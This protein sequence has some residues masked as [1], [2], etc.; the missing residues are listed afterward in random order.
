MRA[1]ELVHPEDRPRVEAQ[2]A[3][4]VQ[5]VTVTEPIQFRVEHADGTYRYAEAVVSNLRDNPSVAG[6]RRQPARHHRAQGG[7][8]PAPPRGAARP[9]HRAS[10]TAP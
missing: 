9:A 7:R 6:L 1:T 3:A 5:T 2:L 4:L 8:V 10:R